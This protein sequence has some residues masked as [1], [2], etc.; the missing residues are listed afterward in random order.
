[1]QSFLNTKQFVSIAGIN[2]VI[3]RIT[4][5]VA[6]GSTLGPLLFFLYSNDLP[7]FTNCLPR[8]FADD[9]CLVI[10]SPELDTLENVMN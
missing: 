9:T 6:Q 4:Y 8:L 10:K 2:S 3:E 7:L 1:M 5:G